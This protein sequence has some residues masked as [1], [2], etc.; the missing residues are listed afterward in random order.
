MGGIL[1][2]LIERIT[3]GK[4]AQLSESFLINDQIEENGEWSEIKNASLF[5]IKNKFD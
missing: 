4:Y 5:N 2:K 3:R 1:P